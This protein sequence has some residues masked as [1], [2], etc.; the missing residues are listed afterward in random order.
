M[1]GFVSVVVAVSPVSLCAHH[2]LLFVVSATAPNNSSPSFINIGLC[3]R[4]AT[5]YNYCCS[6]YIVSVPVVFVA[7]VLLDDGVYYLLHASTLLLLLLL[8]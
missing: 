4:Y 1:K 2:P 3:H 7:D 6:F 8:L 5:N